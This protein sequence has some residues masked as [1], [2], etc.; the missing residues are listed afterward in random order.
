MTTFY[1]IRH[2]ATLFTDM[3]RIQGWCDSPLTQNGIHQMED[4]RN[5]LA[6]IHFDAIYSSNSGRAVESAR[7]L[8]SARNMKVCQMEELREVGYGS[9]EGELYRI[10]YPDGDMD[11]IGYARYGGEDLYTA[12]QRFVSAIQQI[13]ND[14]PNANI[15]IVTSGHIIKQVLAELDHRYSAEN[16]RT[17]ALIPDCSVTRLVV[18]DNQFSLE[19]LP[20]ISWRSPQIGNEFRS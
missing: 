9:L 4:L 8:A 1:I 12:K 7:I 5:G 11:P 13:A 15:A 16:A 20:D 19:A 10:A 17:T 6:G 14:H 2:G 3:E 18:A